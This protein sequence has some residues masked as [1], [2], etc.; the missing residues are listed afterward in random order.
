MTLSETITYSTTLLRCE[1]ATPGVLSMGTGFIMHLCVN[2]NSCIPV[3][4]TNKHVIENAVS[5]KFALC[6]RNPDGSPN[7][8]DVK[9]IKVDVPGSWIMHP[10]P[11][12]DLCCLPIGDIINRLIINDEP[13]VLYTALGTD[14]IP[15][16][17]E[18][19]NFSAMENIIMVGY[20]AGIS[21][22]YNN[23]PILR[24][25]ITATHIKYDYKNTK[26]FLIDAACFNGSSGSP[27]FILDEGAFLNKG[28]LVAGGRIKF[29]GV[30]YAGPTFA[31]NGE[32][33]FT[34]IPTSPRT[35]TQI[36][37]N[38][39]IVIKASEILAFEPLLKQFCNQ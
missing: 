5:C 13:T 7:D 37:I 28:A 22:T 30:L 1:L 24:R 18:I 12:I 34:T 38:L 20:P 36:P 2:D 17:E 11:D 23:K 3:L 21:D 31:V 15:T 39:G 29:I 9:W 19:N 32:I 25:G 10:N 14:I 16:Q 26:T 8:T 33:V 27:V 6:T 4:I 35:I